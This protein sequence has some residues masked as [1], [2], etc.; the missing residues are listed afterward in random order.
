MF[1]LVEPRVGAL[2][3]TL[4]LPPVVGAVF[5]DLRKVY[6]G[7]VVQTQDLTVFNVTTEAVVARQA[8]VQPQQMAVA[9]EPTIEPTTGERPE[10]PAWWAESL[11]PIDDVMAL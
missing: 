4:L 7:P 3:H 6:D 10:P 8:Q 5:A 9:G 2:W 11:I 1:L